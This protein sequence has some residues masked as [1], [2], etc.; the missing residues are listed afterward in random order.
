MQVG[1]GTEGSAGE[2]SSAH[3]LPDPSSESTSLSRPSSLH[4]D[5]LVSGLAVAAAVALVLAAAATSDSD[6]LDAALLASAS[7]QVVAGMSTGPT[8]GPNWAASLVEGG[9]EMEES[10]AASLLLGGQEIASLA[11]LM[12]AY[13]LVCMDKE[14]GLSAAAAKVKPVEV[15]DL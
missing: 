5:T 11:S 6:T 8:V 2:T 7:C 14:E 9:A 15:V 4:H 10:N 13:A 12:K 3:A 1:G